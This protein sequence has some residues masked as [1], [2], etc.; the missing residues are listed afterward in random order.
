MTEGGDEDADGMISK[1][2]FEDLLNKEKAISILGE[3]GVDGVQLLDLKDTLFASD[4]EFDDTDG[5]KLT[6]AEFMDLILDLRGCNNATVKDMV[7]LRKYID[8]RFVR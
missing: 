4:S 3:V 1:K 8:N 2:E 5:R 7:T 6:F